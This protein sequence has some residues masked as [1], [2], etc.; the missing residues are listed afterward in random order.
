MK[1]SNI[2]FSKDEICTIE[3]LCN[4]VLTLDLIEADDYKD[5]R[6]E[7]AQVLS[8]IANKN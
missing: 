2:N 3:S 6:G 8:K 5:F 4:I 7:I 1:D